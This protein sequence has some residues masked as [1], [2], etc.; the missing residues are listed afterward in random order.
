MDFYYTYDYPANEDLLQTIN[1]AMLTT[2]D[3]FAIADKLHMG[4]SDVEKHILAAA[5]LAAAKNG[6][7]KKTADKYDVNSEQLSQI[8]EHHPYLYTIAFPPVKT[9]Q[10]LQREL[11]NLTDRFEK[12]VN[13]L[14]FVTIVKDQQL[15]VE[16]ERLQVENQRLLT[17]IARLTAMLDKFSQV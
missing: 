2:S 11:R 8:I 1:I 4:V 3:L 16:T 10:E 7:I 6:N 9:N 13:D 17:E 15:R 12:F 5:A 14:N